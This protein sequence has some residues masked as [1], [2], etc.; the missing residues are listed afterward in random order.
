LQA[1]E[2]FDFLN[3]HFDSLGVL[4]T[5]ISTPPS[6]S[7]SPASNPVRPMAHE[8]TNINLNTKDFGSINSSAL[9]ARCIKKFEELRMCLKEIEHE[10]IVRRMVE[11]ALHSAL[12]EIQTQN[13]MDTRS[14]LIYS[15]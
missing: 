9:P 7:T 4:L 14:S 12:A 3:P 15:M 11:A 5:T 6:Q 13:M 10:K 1:S 8:Q 2:S